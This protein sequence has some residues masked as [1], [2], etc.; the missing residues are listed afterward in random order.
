MRTT[1][2]ILLLAIVAIP[3]LNSCK[4]EDPLTNAQ[5]IGAE[6]NQFIKDHNIKYLIAY[7]YYGSS[8]TYDYYYTSSFGVEDSFFRVD[9]V[10]FSL[11]NLS[12]YYSDYGYYTDSNYQVACLHLEFN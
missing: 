5:K 6:L 1:K 4:K 10:K 8:S 11:E 7:K 12:S 9:K 3:F 2:I